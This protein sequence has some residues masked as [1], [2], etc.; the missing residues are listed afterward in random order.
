MRILT[1][2]IHSG[3]DTEL[4]KTGHEF[5]A[6]T[7]SKPWDPGIRVPPPNWHFIDSLD[8]MEFDLIL[9]SHAWELF[10]RFKDVK[11]PMIF[12]IIADCSEGI[13]PAKIEERCSAVAFL[14]HEVASR[15]ELKDEAKKIVIEMGVDESPFIQRTGDIKKCLTVGHRIGKR[16][17]KGHCPYVTTSQFLPLNLVGPGNEDMPGALGTLSHKELMEAYSRYRVY[18]N[19]GPIIGISV[20][21]AMMAA[22]PIV[23]FRPINLGGL[24]RD[25]VNGYVVDTVDGAV[26]KLSKLIEDEALAKQMGLKAQGTARHLFSSD[27]FVRN[28]NYLFNKVA[29]KKQ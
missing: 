9:V 17:D 11:A 10:E 6:T 29:E 12:N 13:F 3:Y 25:G 5:F 4:A 20:A 24:I 14:A 7:Y 16:W 21:E 8:G 27:R 1:H 19:P 18:F 15:W 28:W 26:M 22:L 2:N 23:T